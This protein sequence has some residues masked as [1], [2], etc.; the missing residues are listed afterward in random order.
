MKSLSLKEYAGLRW[1]AFSR[2]PM[3]GTQIIGLV[4]GAFLVLYFT[5]AAVGL[6]A[7]AGP[8]LV[9][10]YGEDIRVYEYVLQFVVF[11]YGID[12]G[13]RV[14][15]QPSPRV[16]LKP[17]FTLPVRKKKLLLQQ[18]SRPLFNVLNWIWFCAFTA[19]AVVNE[20]DQKWIWWLCLMLVPLCNSY[21]ISMWKMF[22][23]KKPGIAYPL[24]LFLLSPTILATAGIGNLGELIGTW[25]NYSILHIWPVIFALVVLSALYLVHYRL[26]IRL[27]YSTS[28]ATTA[29][30]GGS[31]AVLDQYG[32][33]G[34]MIN[35]RLKQIWRNKRLKRIILLSPLLIFYAYFIF[36]RAEGEN[37]GLPIMVICVFITGYG[38]IQF[39]QWAFPMD[40]R[41]F[42]FWMTQR[43]TREYLTEK[44]LLLRISV[45][46][47]TLL[48]SPLGFLG[49]SVLGKILIAAIF[50]FGVSIPVLLWVSSYI[51]TKIDTN[52]G[53]AFNMQGFDT[54]TFLSILPV[55]GIP[56]LLESLPYGLWI[57]GGLGVIG[58]L[59]H[60]Y[61]TQSLV[62]HLA[63]KKYEMVLNY[64]KKD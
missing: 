39:G 49:W 29:S 52:D 60:E 27:S 41:E 56:W 15:L 8:L 47:F 26:F 14:A 54:V 43:S 45:I 46:V 20:G 30:S 51:K 11:I 21:V 64:A 37:P 38:A 4:L 16:D 33:T 1:K 6:G 58:I 61:I 28:A 36:T 23:I 40:G 12:L 18:N 44:I 57:M 59:F 50:N 2:S 42:G 9:E 10:Q 22:N 17:L 32:L 34:T 55:M 3:L 53:G 13:M 24:L 63:S 35:T 62:K 19:F 7:V 5:L 31:I 25:L 48:S